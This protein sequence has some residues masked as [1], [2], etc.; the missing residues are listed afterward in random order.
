MAAQATDTSELKGVPAHRRR[1]AR[2]R[3]GWLEAVWQAERESVGEYRGP[4]IRAAV[5]QIKK[6]HPRAVISYQSFYAWERL[7]REFGLAGLVDGRGRPNQ[8]A[9]IERK[10]QAVSAERLSVREMIAE[11][12]RL[13]S[14]A[15]AEWN[16]NPHK[17]D[18]GSEEETAE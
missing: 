9:L 17:V 3:L 18:M 1:V 11:A 12:Q 16:S 14:L 6:R 4:V 7:Y 13:L 8:R 5:A 15:L 10:G 2:Q